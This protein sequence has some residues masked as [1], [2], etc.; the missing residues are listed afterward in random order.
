[1]WWGMRITAAQKPLFIEVLK[2]QTHC[3]VHWE[4]NGSVNLCKVQLYSF[5]FVIPA[6]AGIQ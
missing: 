3:C 1:M 5:I 2:P 6:Q 4:D